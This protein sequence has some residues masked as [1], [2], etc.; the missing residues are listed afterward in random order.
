MTW[1]STARCS[2]LSIRFKERVA[3]IVIVKEVASESASVTSGIDKRLTQVT[4]LMVT[5]TPFGIKSQLRC[6]LLQHQQYENLWNY[7]LKFKYKPFGT[8]ILMMDHWYVSH[9]KELNLWQVALRSQALRNSTFW[10]LAAIQQL[11]T[12]SSQFLLSKATRSRLYNMGFSSSLTCKIS[13]PEGPTLGPL[14]GFLI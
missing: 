10:Q 3:N 6:W 11:H 2:T 4:P 1:P 7:S 13:A 12:R 8:A 14:F 5:Y 9:Q